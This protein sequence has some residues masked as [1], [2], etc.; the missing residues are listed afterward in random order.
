M[1]FEIVFISAE[2]HSFHFRGLSHIFTNFIAE[3]LLFLIV[4]NSIFN[5]DFPIMLCQTTDSLNLLDLYIL[6]LCH[7]DLVN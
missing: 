2:F 1:F 7:L 5:L 4:T 6:T 3:C